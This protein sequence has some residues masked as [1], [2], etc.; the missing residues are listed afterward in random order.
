MAAVVLTRNLKPPHSWTRS[1]RQMEAMSAVA[2]WSVATMTA[3]TACYGRHESFSLI[4][5]MR[6]RGLSN[7]IQQP[8]KFCEGGIIL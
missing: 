4:A 6:R 7:I 2:S 8:E 1:C 3:T 5:G